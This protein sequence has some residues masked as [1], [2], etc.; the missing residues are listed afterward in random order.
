[1]NKKNN[2]FPLALF[3]GI[4]AFAFGGF[5]I[6]FGAFNKAGF[7]GNRGDEF[8]SIFVFAFG[9]IGL[10][11]AAL[12]VRFIVVD[13]R[14]KQKMRRLL[15]SGSRVSAEIVGVEN[16]NI[17]V[18]GSAGYYLVCRHTEGGRDYI[19]RSEMLTGDMGDLI[20]R[21]IDVLSNRDFSEYYVD[22]DSL[23]LSRNA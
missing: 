11:F 13:V 16:A 20:G 10:L 3:F 12:T 1:M 6:M 2:D 19:L 9:A 7:F 15:K 14:G 4:F 21:H 22:T 17:S 18:N 23:Y 5:A 8:V